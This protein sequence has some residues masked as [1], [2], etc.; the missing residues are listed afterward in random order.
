MKIR[1]NQYLIFSVGFLSCAL[2]FVTM[3][4]QSPSV[5]P[6]LKQ[7]IH[8]LQNTVG[9]LSTDLHTLR[10]DYEELKT[11]FESQPKVKIDPEGKW[12]IVGD[13]FMTWGTVTMAKHRNNGVQTK[14]V[15]FPFDETR[16]IGF[17]EKPAVTTS[18]LPVNTNNNH[19]STYAVYSSTTTKKSFS[20]GIYR[21]SSNAR[22]T[23]EMS[24]MAV[25]KLITRRESNS[26]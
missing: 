1:D 23:V 26:E 13:Q 25:G 5:Q 10:A 24:Y 12:M 19:P 14:S 3:G 15:E 16:G 8:A 22:P 6:S 4:A 9:T 20:L 11:T 7:Q 17:Q 21:V 18:F 2:I